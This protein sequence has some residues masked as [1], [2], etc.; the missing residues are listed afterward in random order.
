MSVVEDL[1]RVGVLPVVVIDDA[2]DAADLA[3]ALRDGGVDC[4]EITL[5]TPAG[6]AAIE[7]ASTEGLLVGAGTVLDRPQLEAAVGAG[8][9]FA[10][11]PGWSAEVV[12]ACREL[13]VVP[14]PGVATAT[15]VMTA[16]AEGLRTLKLFP[17]A[18]LGG[19]AAIAA[20]NGPFPDVRFVPSG[21]IG[22]DEAPS[23][24]IDPVV[25][26]ST[27]WIAPRALIREHRFSEITER[28]LAFRRAVG[29]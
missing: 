11:S 23:Y 15:E 6:M 25:S 20:L 13:D 5:R 1:A 22:I 4:A 27:S 8:A 10:V 26:V 3:R 17:A 29:R 19:P 12:R 24:M 28:A 16:M 9:R 2:A 14:I 18:Q 21:G 7:A